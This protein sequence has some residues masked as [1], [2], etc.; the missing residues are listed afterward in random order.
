M[1]ALGLAVPQGFVIPNPASVTAASLA[2]AVKKLGSKAKPLLL[3]VRPSVNGQAR[4]KA[5]NC[6]IVQA[7]IQNCFHVAAF[8]G[9]ETGTHRQ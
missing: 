6:F 4:G 5:F 3:A 9:V 1:L 7:D 8:V 2:A